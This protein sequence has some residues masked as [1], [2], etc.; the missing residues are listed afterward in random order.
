MFNLGLKDF[1][2]HFLID[3]YPYTHIYR[4]FNYPTGEE[5][6]NI[7][8]GIKLMSGR[9][10][11]VVNL[12]KDCLVSEVGKPF[13]DCNIPPE[14]DGCKCIELN[15]DIYRYKKIVNVTRVEVIGKNGREF[16]KW[17]KNSHYEINIQDDGRTIKLLEK[18]LFD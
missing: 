6:S 15:E 2:L 5:I 16:S 12:K 8:R 9:R 7:V 13:Y 10:G 11:L 14:V 18:G 3:G 17:L 4:G 1:S